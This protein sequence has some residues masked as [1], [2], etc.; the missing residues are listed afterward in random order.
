M[1]KEN[2]AAALG[3]DI[4][5][6]STSETIWVELINKKGAFTKLDYTIDPVGSKGTVMIRK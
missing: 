1:I 5:V 6:D 3:E 4:L 2:F